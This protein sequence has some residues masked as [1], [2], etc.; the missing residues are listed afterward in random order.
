M[1]VPFR[2]L[3]CLIAVAI[4]LPPSGECRPSTFL[5]EEFE[6]LEA[7]KPLTFPK[8]ASHSD[9]TTTS[10]SETTSML[11][12]K[13][14][15]SA[16]G[17]LLRRTFNVFHY[18]VLEWKWKVDSVY[19]KGDATQKSGD[20]YPI[21]V[22]VL[23]R[24]NPRTASW[25]DRARY[26]TARL[27]YKEYPPVATL[28]YIWANKRHSSPVLTSPYADAAK[29]IAV[30]QGEEFVGTW[31]THQRNILD[32]YRMAFGAEPPPIAGI[33]IMNDS[34]NTGESSTSYLDFIEV[35]AA[36]TVDVTP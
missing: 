33:A 10:A 24:Y 4:A 11:V 20:D 6:S 22:F 13:S 12:A 5:R 9:Y 35:R 30:D 17:M 34:D 36:T 15:S 16:S 3:L 7:W 32:D 26:E 14:A 29:L 21:R 19:S 1:K 28:S 2:S 18:P 8:I 31:R 27:L 25:W 23:F